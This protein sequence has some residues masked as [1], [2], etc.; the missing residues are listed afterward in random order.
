[1]QATRVIM[2]R[3]RAEKKLVQKCLLTVT[4]GPDKGKKA[5]LGKE[6]ITVG[7][8]AGA[9]L[10]LADE[11]ISSTHF[12]IEA[13]ERGFVLK[14]LGSTNGTY[15]QGVRVFEALIEDGVSFSAGDTTFKFNVEKDQVSVPLSPRDRFGDLLGT[16]AKMREVFA[17]LEK[18]S[19]SDATVLLNGETGTGKDL[20]ARAIHQH[21][22]RSERPFIVLDC[23]A[24]PRE[25]FESAV[26]GHE[27]G[28]FTGA[29][30]KHPGAFREATGGTLFLDEVGELDISLQPKLLRALQNREVTPVGS[31]KPIAVDVRVIAATHRNLQ[32]LV[33]RGAFRED[34]Y[35]RLAV[36]SV[37]MPPLRVRPEDVVAIVKA[38]LDARGG[39]R[40]RIDEE[41]MEFVKG[42]PWP[43]NVRE[44][45]NAILRALA[46]CEG[47]VITKRDL[48]FSARAGGAA[49]VE[50][51]FREAK[52][53]SVDAFE[54]D[55]LKELVRKTGGNLTRA[56][57][58]A[59]IQR[60][61]L[62]DLLRKHQINYKDP[63]SVG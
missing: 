58:I 54:R 9:D 16:G 24:I 37:E 6:R 10:Q 11:A 7:R 40:M 27:I 35:F 13:D 22:L 5:S 20:A 45:E 8:F 53:R 41:A 33:A 50:G 32:D 4:A 51:P 62:R 48:V 14:D 30:R 29:D 60:H 47:G 36:V 39:G 44:L 56:S 19:A 43:G 49:P 31:N 57:E 63:D 17:I 28:A 18:A 42:Q 46:L 3:G 38:I 15:Y 61:H 12:A 55:Y 21:S 34:L 26:F 25:L 59:E 23:A 52:Q 1:M 2:E